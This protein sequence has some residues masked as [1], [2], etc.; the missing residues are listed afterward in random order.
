MLSALFLPVFFSIRNF[1]GSDDEGSLLYRGV[2]PVIKG[3][4]TVVDTKKLTVF[5]AGKSDD[6]AND[7][8][9]KKQRMFSYF[10]I[11]ELSKGETQLNKVYPDI[12]QQVKKN[13]LKK[14][15]GYIQVPQIY[16]NEK[17]PLY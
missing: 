3:K 17:V 1:S 5:S 12:K 2:A 7:H 15:I 8:R 11:E 9:N 16:G 4:K 14:G 6:F 10:L 13:S